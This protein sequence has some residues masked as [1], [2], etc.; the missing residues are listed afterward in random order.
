MSFPVSAF[1]FFGYICDWNCWVVSIFSFLRKFNTASYGGCTNVH[2]CQQCATIPFFPH[3][4]QHLLFVVFLV[5]ALLTNV[6]W[7][8]IVDLIYNSLMINDIEHLFMCLFII[9]LSSLEKYIFRS[10]AHFLI[11][12][13][14]FCY[15]EG[16]KGW[17]EKVLGWTEINQRYSLH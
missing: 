14:F 6:R 8:V 16:F 15:L 2:P 5:I 1:V 4:L 3:P 7:Y 11:R 9:S 12:L 13:L 17:S 10:S